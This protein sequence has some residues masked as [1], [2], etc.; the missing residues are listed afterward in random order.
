[1]LNGVRAITMMWTV[2]GTTFVNY[3]VGAINILTV[4]AVFARPFILII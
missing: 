3:L 4:D 2:M 1:M